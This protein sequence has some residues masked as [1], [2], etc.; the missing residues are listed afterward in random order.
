MIVKR[1]VESITGYRY[2]KV[3]RNAYNSGLEYPDMLHIECEP[4]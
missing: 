1:S 3:F 2:P 4:M